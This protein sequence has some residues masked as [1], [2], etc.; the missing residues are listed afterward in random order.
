MNREQELTTYP[1]DK[2]QLETELDFLVSYFMNFGVQTCNVL[3]GF[4]WG[5]KYYPTKEW[6]AETVQLSELSEKLKEV[7]KMDIGKLGEDDLFVEFDN[8]EFQFC[9]ESDIHIHC[10]EKSKIV[11]EFYTRW[12]EKGYQ[13]SWH[14]K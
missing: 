4:A 13:P 1:L 10:D 9:H 12:E 14:S 3:F 6:V 5:I 8:L 2:A 11:N 7:E